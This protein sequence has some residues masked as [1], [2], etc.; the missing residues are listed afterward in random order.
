MTTENVTWVE[1]EILFGI[2]AMTFLLELEEH[3]VTEEA[4]S[5]CW[6]PPA[7]RERAAMP[8]VIVLLR[9]GPGHASG[10]GLSYHSCPGRVLADS[11]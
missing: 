1:K 10:P 6:P 4:V 7:P 3:L 2:E 8:L 9:S 5:C 11:P